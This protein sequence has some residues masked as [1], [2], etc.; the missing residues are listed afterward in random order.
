MV[1]ARRDS[2]STAAI[3]HSLTTRE[4]SGRPAGA[5]LEDF[6][7]AASATF[8]F[9]GFVEGVPYP[10]LS[11]AQQDVFKADF[12]KEVASL[13]AWCRRES[14]SP[15][16]PAELQ[17]FVS[18]EYRISRSLVPASLNRRGRIEFP[19]WKAIAGEA[20]I[21]HELTHVYFPNG[22]RFLAEGLAVYMQAKIGGNPAFPN[23]GKPLHEMTRALLAA[24]VGQ[25]AAEDLASLAK[26]RL[27]DLD[28]IATPSPL[29]LRI[30]RELYDNNPV[31]QA[32]IYPLVGSFVQFLMDT[33]GTDRFRALFTMTPLV[34]FERDAGSPDRWIAVYRHS[35]GDLEAQWKSLIATYPAPSSACIGGGTAERDAAGRRSAT[36]VGQR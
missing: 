6:G 33:Y 26:L 28:K 3:V 15:S 29:R 11:A 23:F 7:E 16:P 34:P 18:D 17:I 35:L 36:A 19:A 27:T 22:N 24:M 14:W 30:G 13:R 8:H 25:F 9:D 31:G 5:T 4:Q 2:S 32:H 10:S 1:V 21:A 20:V 12:F